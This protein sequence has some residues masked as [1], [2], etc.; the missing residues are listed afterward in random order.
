VLIATVY[1]LWFR[2][3]KSLEEKIQKRV[4][5][6]DS[7]SNQSEDTE[8]LIQK[9]NEASV[10]SKMLLGF[11]AYTNTI[12]LFKVTKIPGQIDCLHGIRVIS[13]LWVILGHSFLYGSGLFCNSAF[14]IF[15][16]ICE[17]NSF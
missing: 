17:F 10:V 16:N 3:E 5:E 15:K 9:P 1:D 7:N 8:Y 11:S 13:L 4:N 14:Y 12:N 6:D 2:A